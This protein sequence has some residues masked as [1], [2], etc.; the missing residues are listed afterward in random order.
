MMKSYVE[1]YVGDEYG[2]AGLR[3]FNGV[4]MNYLEISGGEYFLH[5]VYQSSGVET[6]PEGYLKNPYV[7]NEAKGVGPLIMASTYAEKAARIHNNPESYTLSGTEDKTLLL[8]E[9]PDFSNVELSLHFDN[10]SDRLIT[11]DELIFE[12]SEDY[13]PAVP[14]TYTVTVSYNGIEYGT[15]QVTFE[16][17]TPTFE[18]HSL[19]LTGEIGVNFYMDL[20]GDPA[21]YEDSYMTF[22]CNGLDADPVYPDPGFMNDSG[23]YGF[24]CYVNTL[25]MAEKITAVFHYGEDNAETVEDTYSVLEYL[26]IA[27]DLHA[28]DETSFPQEAAQVASALKEYGYFAQQYLSRIH[29]FSLGEGG[30]YTGIPELGYTVYYQ[31][32]LEN[33]LTGKEDHLCTVE[34]GEN[35]EALAGLSYSLVLDSD[36]TVNIYYRLNDENGEHL[37]YTFHGDDFSPQDFSGTAEKLSDGRYLISVR[38]IPAHLLDDEFV[39]KIGGDL[40]ELHLRAV[41][42][43]L[44]VLG[45]DSY[46][47]DMKFVM[48]SIIKYCEDVIKYRDFLQNP[49]H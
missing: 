11:K 1:G 23:W 24:T 18:S 36:T 14:G 8:N 27:N 32:D 15:I 47:D 12:E 39:I 43:A 34:P 41:S 44:D 31:N 48:L 35:V 7:D 4:V 42:Y 46:P 25:Q 30:K 37:S 40:V 49:T 3:A 5:N 26:N 20:P 45:N 22:S 9:V 13:D 2:E 19:V 16:L 10:G 17:P 6:S 38:N 28:Q 21:Y 33:A 29:G